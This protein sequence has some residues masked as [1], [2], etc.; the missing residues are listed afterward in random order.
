MASSDSS[1]DDSEHSESES[2]EDTVIKHNDK[3]EQAIQSDCKNEIDLTELHPWPERHD[4]S[5]PTRVINIEKVTIAMNEKQIFE[6]LF[7]D[8][9]SE[10]HPMHIRLFHNRHH[11]DK[12]GFGQIIFNKAHTVESIMPLLKQK[13][14]NYNNKFRLFRK[15]ILLDI[16]TDHSVHNNLKDNTLRL[17]F[18]NL[19]WKCK[20]S[21][22]YQ[23]IKNCFT[24]YKQNNADVKFKL[25]DVLP[26]KI[27]IIEDH[28]GFTTGCAFV[29]FDSATTASTVLFA[30][31]GN[32][33]MDQNV[34]VD[35]HPYPK[36]IKSWWKQQQGW[37]KSRSTQTLL[38]C[39]LHASITENDIRVFIEKHLSKINQQNALR[40]IHLI[41]N[42]NNPLLCGYALLFF[43]GDVDVFDTMEQLM[44]RI[45]YKVLHHRSIF[46]MFTR[47]KRHQNT[48]HSELKDKTRFVMI[49]NLVW[50]V[51]KVNLSQFIGRIGGDK[52][53]EVFHSINIIV[54]ANGYP[55]GKALVKCV[56][57]EIATQMVCELDGKLCRDREVMMDWCDD[58]EYQSIQSKH[59]NSFLNMMDFSSHFNST[60]M[61]YLRDQLFGDHNFGCFGEL[62]HRKRGKRHL[63][64]DT[65][66]KNADIMNKYNERVVNKRKQ[67]KKIFQQAK[68]SMI[69]ERMLKEVKRG[70]TLQESRPKTPGEIRAIERKG[71]TG[72]WTK[73]GMSKGEMLS[74]K[75][76]GKTGM[77]TKLGM[78]KGEMLSLKRKVDWNTGKSVLSKVIA[79][80][81]TIHVKDYWKDSLKHARKR[82]RNK[83]YIQKTAKHTKHRKR[84]GRKK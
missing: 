36:R 30:C 21:H 58:K 28:H 5:F 14:S 6:T 53:E 57:P 15:T 67:R 64:E 1:S 29:D 70:K 68:T 73:L 39:N 72:M 77:W 71:K 35:W 65:Q 74:L 11:L 4:D 13:Q 51:N 66:D 24:K 17:V 61:N 75:R 26:I 59:N 46:V 41:H 31:H 2:D 43:A 19:Y 25:R 63:G 79:S 38:M 50:D 69:D 56:S 55:I 22:I 10:C 47:N 42:R 16:V 49:D 80:K 18:V 40:D 3:D 62:K 9:P 23:F 82:N 84:D 76:K 45:Q 60:Q 33:L 81:R 37:K 34:Y 12:H 78:S 48:K 20:A 44:Q 54:D 32:T 7:H 8:I 83:W 27:Q 52:E